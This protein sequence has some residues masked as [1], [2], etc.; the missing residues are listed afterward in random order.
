MNVDATAKRNHAGLLE[1]NDETISQA[2]TLGPV[3]PARQPGTLTHHEIVTD[4]SGRNRL[5]EESMI[6]QRQ[7]GKRLYGM[8]PAACERAPFGRST[9]AAPDRARQNSGASGLGQTPFGTDADKFYQHPEEAGTSEYRSALTYARHGGAH[10]TFASVP[11]AA[12]GAKHH[13]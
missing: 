5:Q 13:K 6:D 8:P 11:G 3:P 7:H 10:G 12:K 9:D 2:R 1:W 4:R